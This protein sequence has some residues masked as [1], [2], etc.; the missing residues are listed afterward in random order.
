MQGRNIL[1][2]MIRERSCC[3]TM[4]S[5]TARDHSY[6]RMAQHM[7]RLQFVRFCHMWPRRIMPAR[8]SARNFRNGI[9]IIIAFRLLVRV[10]TSAESRTRGPPESPDDDYH[11]GLPVF[12]SHLD[13]QVLPADHHTRQRRV[14]ASI[15][16]PLPLESCC[17]KT[18]FIWQV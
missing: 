15:K 18:L 7:A 5:R 3:K 16:H 9:S 2:Q 11:D 12:K 10:M 8:A 1:P 13:T 14:Q 17:R 4:I 6:Q